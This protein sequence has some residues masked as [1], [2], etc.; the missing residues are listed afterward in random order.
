MCSHMA[1]RR[2]CGGLG[3]APLTSRD[4]MMKLTGFISTTASCMK[5]A[6]SGERPRIALH[7]VGGKAPYTTGATR[8]MMSIQMSF[9]SVVAHTMVLQLSG[10]AQ[11]PFLY[12]GRPRFAQSG[13]MSAPPMALFQRRAARCLFRWSGSPQ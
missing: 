5:M 12:K 11:S 2:R 8:F 7:I 13:G 1:C 6:S 9:A 4:M 3:N 10:F